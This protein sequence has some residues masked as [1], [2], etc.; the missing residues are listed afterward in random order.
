MTAQFHPD[1]MLAFLREHLPKRDALSLRLFLSPL[2]FLFL[3]TLLLA[4]PALTLFSD[5]LGYAFTLALFLTAAMAWELRI[6]GDPH[7]PAQW[8]KHLFLLL[9]LTLFFAQTLSVPET[10]DLPVSQPSSF[11]WI[12]DLIVQE[13]YALLNLIPDGI[14]RFFSNW[15][16]STV[17]FLFFCAMCV[18][19]QLFRLSAFG[20]ILFIPWILTL[21]DGFIPGLFSGGILLFIGL[22]RLFN[23]IP[24]L[25]LQSGAIKLQPLAQEDPEFV[26]SA[27]RILCHVRDGKSHPL[28]EITAAHPQA[29]QEI[30]RIIK[31]GLLEMRVTVQGEE[32]ILANTLN[33][34]SPLAVFSRIPRAIFLLLIVGFWVILPIDLIPDPLPFIGTFDDITLSILAFYSLREKDA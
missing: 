18:R 19:H 5:A 1:N 8:P 13:F 25:A 2:L 21:T 23:P 15:R 20:C 34:V 6:L 26:C 24:I 14:V 12:G 17:L 32:V 29:A 27:L 4:E 28:S 31:L 22:A 11:G 7:H 9:T 10:T 30:M 3:S 33:R 16:I